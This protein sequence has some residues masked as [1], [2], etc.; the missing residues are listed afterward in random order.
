MCY[1]IPINCKYRRYGDCA[2]DSI[3]ITLLTLLWL[4]C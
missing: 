3:L 1:H 2:A 4:C